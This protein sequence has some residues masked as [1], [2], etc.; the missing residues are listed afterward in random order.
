LREKRAALEEEAEAEAEAEM[1]VKAA[2]AVM[3]CALEAGAR[4][5][6]RV[7]AEEA[8]RANMVLCCC[9]WWWRGCVLR[10]VSE[11]RMQSEAKS[12]GLWIN[13]AILHFLETGCSYEQEKRTWPAPSSA[14]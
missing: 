11:S 9:G 13:Q 3:R 2:A 7:A 12:G 14:T 8:E 4:A 5:V 1:G 10:D 6:T